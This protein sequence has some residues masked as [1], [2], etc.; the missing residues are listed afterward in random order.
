MT[1]NVSEGNTPLFS[2]STNGLHSEVV[3]G[4]LCPGG[5][6][7]R[8]CP[9]AL[10]QQGPETFLSSFWQAW[11]AVLLQASLHS[12]F[13]LTLVELSIRLWVCTSVDTQ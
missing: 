7:K 13:P 4:S 5:P 2:F 9:F 6:G 10:S 8:P 3:V 11:T 1:S 12:F